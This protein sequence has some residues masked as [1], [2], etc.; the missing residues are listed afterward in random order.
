EAVWGNILQ[1][2]KKKEIGDW[3]LEDINLQ[4]LISNLPP[5]IDFVTART[6]FY[7]EPT[8]LP[9]VA[10]GSIKLDLHRRDFAI[11]TLAVRLDGAF[12]GQLLDFYGG[13]QDLED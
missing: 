1:R 4:S 8:A 10:H 2:D 6:E 13:Q 3:R 11:N 9:E 7:T 12:L 5:T